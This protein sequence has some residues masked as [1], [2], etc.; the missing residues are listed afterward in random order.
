MLQR[1]QTIYLLVATLVTGSLFFQKL[2]SF[3]SSTNLYIMKFN[4]I[5]TA[6]TDN[7]E[8]TMSTLAFTILLGLSVAMGLVT[9]FL[10]KKRMIQ[11]RLC[12]LN[13]GLMLGI[14][15]MIYY[16]AKTGARELAAEYTFHFPIVLPLIAI[17]L[18][19][20]AIKAIGRDEALIRSM[21]RI[22]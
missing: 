3:I 17:I 2:V 15:G 10:F 14:T 8:L 20:M 21:D 13:I 7:P 1:K 18:T 4:G 11:I 19:V 6:K 5:F 9:V 16:F 12:A 22:R